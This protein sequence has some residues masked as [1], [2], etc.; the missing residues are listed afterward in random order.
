MYR[1]I[2]LFALATTVLLTNASADPAT[3]VEETTAPQAAVVA[4]VQPATTDAVSAVVTA[5][6]TAV[7]ASAEPAA[8]APAA[9]TETK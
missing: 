3:A 6:P 7:T 8:E 4:E 5:E 1:F 9:S 2:L